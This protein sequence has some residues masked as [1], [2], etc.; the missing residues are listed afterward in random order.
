MVPL[1]FIGR[2]E[3]IASIRD[4]LGSN[5]NLAAMKFIVLHG[6]PLVGKSALAK[7]LVFTFSS[8][9][10]DRHLVVDMRG[11]TSNYISVRFP[12]STTSECGRVLT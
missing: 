12:D 8:M 3:E 5:K 1:N 10:P 9:Y 6:S 2:E 11:V 7:Q 4:F